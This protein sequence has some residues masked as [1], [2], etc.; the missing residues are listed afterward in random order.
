[1]TRFHI[2]DSIMGSGKTSAMLR[3]LS[4]PW[5]TS[6]HYVIVV[7]TLSEVDRWHERLSQPYLPTPVAPEYR[8]DQ[9]KTDDFKNL[10][11]RH[12]RR[13]IITHAMFDRVDA[14][15]VSLLKERAYCLIIDEVPTPVASINLPPGDL[16]MLFSS[17]T[18]LVNK[19][20]G[21]VVW[22]PDYEQERSSY[23]EL[24][25]LCGTGKVFYNAEANW[26]F[27]VSPYDAYFAC[28][29]VYILTYMFEAQIIYY[30]FKQFG[31][32]YD[33]L[34]VSEDEEDGE[35]YL[36]DYSK[37][38]DRLLDL[39]SLIHI[40]QSQRMNAVGKSKNALSLNWFKRHSGEIPTLKKNIS[41]FC[42]HTAQAKSSDV[43]WTTFRSFKG[44]IETRGYKSGFLALNAKATNDFSDKTTVLY[45]VNRFLAPSMLHYFN[46]D[47]E[48]IKVDEDAFALSE[49][50]QFI[51][52]SAIRNGQPI[53]LY[54]PS[55]RMRG[56]LEKWIEENS[57]TKTA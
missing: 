22:N 20:S 50:L 25:K 39:K 54:V 30:Y 4:M 37:V 23:E 17:N 36:V 48:T 33:K 21:N 8:A 57:V 49:M 10:L 5:D 3:I 27:K 12:A 46:L 1:M 11:R 16:R 45:L 29:K 18:L 52:R 38:F 40:C 51:W 32:Q 15:I 55:S 2:V 13:I 43:L 34:S 41:N 53:N 6:S 44:E 31:I 35:Y 14:E 42:R 28:D 9:N 19:E 24:H 7:P 26:L 56:L 47:G